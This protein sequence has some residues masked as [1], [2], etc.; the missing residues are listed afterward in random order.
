MAI[1]SSFVTVNCGTSGNDTIT[2]GSGNDIL[3]GG[4]GSDTLNGGSGNDIIIGGSGNDLLIYNITEN[5]GYKDLYNGSGGADTL[6]VIVDANN[7]SAN[8]AS[9]L[10]G[11]QNGFAAVKL[12]H[13]V[14]FGAYTQQMVGLDMVNIE[15]LQF[16]ISKTINEDAPFT[17]NLADATK[18]QTIQLV[19]G[20]PSYITVN[21]GGASIT[22][23]P[24][25]QYN[26]LGEGES[27]T[28]NFNYQV[29]M[30]GKVI[31]NNTVHVTITGANDLPVIDSIPQTGNVTE[32]IALTAT[33]QFQGHDPDTNDA[34]TWQLVKNGNAYDAITDA[35]GTLTIDPQTGAWTYT[36]TNEAAQSLGA[37]EQLNNLYTVRLADNHDGIAQQD[38]LT[39]HINGTNDSPI[40]DSTVVTSGSVTEN[41]QMD[42]VQGQLVATDVDTN[43]AG[44]LAWS[45]VADQ[46]PTTEHY[47]TLD[48]NTTT[49]A[50][51]YTLNN[52]DPRL[53]YLNVSQQVSDTFRVQVADEHGGTATQDI[54]INI[55]GITENFIAYNAN[56]LALSA[57]RLL[58][59]NIDASADNLFI[60]G[61]VANQETHGTV[62]TVF[63]PEH[64]AVVSIRYTPDSN[65]TGPANFTYTLEDG[66]GSMS[67]A[68]VN[69]DVYNMIT[70]TAGNDVLI[71]PRDG[72]GSYLVDGLGSDEMHAGTGNN[73]II[74]NTSPDSSD[75]FYFTG[76][77]FGKQNR[78]NVFDSA[79]GDVIKLQDVFTNLPAPTGTDGKYTVADLT[80][81]ITTTHMTTVGGITGTLITVNSNGAEPGGTTHTILL[82]RVN[83]NLETLLNTDSLQIINTT[84]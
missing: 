10:V 26:S 11:M 3:I 54:T 56:S 82:D 81:Y 44:I 61:A 9:L 45:R 55:N 58:S 35:Y 21:A 36:L 78:I 28:S 39:I 12:G 67:T 60:T 37:G 18:G 66:N 2:G 53:E 25:V 71:A 83:T 20:T 43:D 24:R 84:A 48:L 42:T 16:D 6:R 80:D 74:S 27:T 22:F 76:T 30:G 64:T 63:N 68:T 33:G 65:Y 34:L 69:I 40:I 13:Y 59:N 15:K 5:L 75:T 51:N 32:D 17:L 49:G 79:N 31:S 1:I 70:G 50:W 47:G 19:S 62:E 29:S 72:S 38:L 4:A 14:D 73:F 8:E 23:D 57:S 46:D 52:T 7:T 77:D 41:A